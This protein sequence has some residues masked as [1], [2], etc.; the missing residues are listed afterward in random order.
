MSYDH[1]HVHLLSPWLILVYSIFFK[2]L[3]VSVVFQG[4]YLQIPVNPECIQA[5]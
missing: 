2:N 4:F 5:K 1:M 3:F